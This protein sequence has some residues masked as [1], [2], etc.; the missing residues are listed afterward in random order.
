M[1]SLTSALAGTRGLAMCQEI[2]LDR[3][4]AE[5]DEQRRIPIDLRQARIQKM[6]ALTLHKRGELLAARDA[7]KGEEANVFLMMMDEKGADNKPRWSN[8]EARKARVTQLQREDAGY[9]SALARLRK[10]E[11]L[12]SDL[13]MEI[14]ELDEQIKAAAEQ[15]YAIKEQIRGATAAIMAVCTFDGP[16]LPRQIPITLPEGAIVIKLQAPE[17]LPTIHLVSEREAA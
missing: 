5:L 16:T 1:M 3:L 11:D 2:E 13:Q 17:S 4:M 14:N 10:A 9:Q 8:E 15:V 7:L 12:E 6:Q